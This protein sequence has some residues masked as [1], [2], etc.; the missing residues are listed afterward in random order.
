[1]TSCYLAVLLS[2][3][4]FIRALLFKVPLPETLAITLSL[5]SIVFFSIIFG[6]TLPLLLKSLGIDPAHSST[7]IQ[8]RMADNGG[9]GK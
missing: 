9:E 8:V 4:G 3:T 6:A 1:M 7:S 2:L 5:F